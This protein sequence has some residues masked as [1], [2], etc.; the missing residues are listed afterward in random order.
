MR[1][2]L[3]SYPILLLPLHL[4]VALAW[5]RSLWL[6]FVLTVLPRVLVALLGRIVIYGRRPSDTILLP[7][8]AWLYLG[9][10]LPESGAILDVSA[11][12]SV[13][14]ALCQSP[15][16]G[17]L[18]MS[19]FHLGGRLAWPA[20]AVVS[21]V[22]SGH[23]YRMP[24]YDDDAPIAWQ[25]D[26]LLRPTPSPYAWLRSRRSTPGAALYTWMHQNHPDAP[27][28]DWF[29]LQEDALGFAFATYFLG[30]VLALIV[31]SRGLVALVIVLEMAVKSQQG[32]VTTWLARCC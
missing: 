28:E 24:A 29:Y 23:G 22:P 12:G 17:G 32:R 2:L 10:F 19:F 21:A 27:L 8:G 1:R 25:R 30:V 15:T 9:N 7:S 13:E 18:L 4:G 11:T 5:Q 6:L 3:N 16:L 20:E 26:L 14:Y 31:W